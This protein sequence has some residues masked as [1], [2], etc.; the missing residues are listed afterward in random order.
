[1]ELPDSRRGLLLPSM[2]SLESV[3]KLLAKSELEEALL[4]SKRSEM[5]PTLQHKLYNLEKKFFIASL[6][7][8]GS[9]GST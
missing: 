6:V 7:A 1:M 4:D 5:N 2:T 9:P 3:Q 8:W